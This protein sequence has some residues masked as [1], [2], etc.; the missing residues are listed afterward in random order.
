MSIKNYLYQKNLFVEH[1]N[2]GNKSP[3]SFTVE[4][5]INKIKKILEIKA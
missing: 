3:N 1:L 5:S 2:K 4:L